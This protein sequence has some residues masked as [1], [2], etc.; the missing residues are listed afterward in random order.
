MN[1]DVTQALAS[2]LRDGGVRAIDL[3]H[4]L[5]SQSPIIELPPPFHNTPGWSLQEVS[6]YDDRGPWF[7]WNAFSGSEHMGTHFDAPVHWITGRDGVSV[8][9]V[10][11]AQLIGPAVVIDGT[12]QVGSDNDYLL[13]LDLVKAFESKHG[14]VPAGGWVLFRTGWA[15]R[16]TDA[17]EFLLKDDDGHHWPGMTA[18]CARYLAHETEILGYGVEQVGID[19][20]AAHGRIRPIRPTTIC[21]ARASSALHS[22]RILINC[23]KPARSSS[24]HRCESSAVLEALRAS[25]RSWALSDWPDSDL[26]V[27]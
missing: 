21:S 1:T 13:D 26:E 22:S 8:D 10:T 18:E 3:T 17:S 6:R 24:P 9:Q 23:L 4:P 5:S 27:T 12:Q 20:G 2:A 14:P 15:S 16:Y 7:Y 19:G 11:P 25:L